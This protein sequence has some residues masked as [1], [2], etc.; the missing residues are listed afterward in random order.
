MNREFWKDRSVFLTGHTGFKG[1]WTALWLSQLGAKVHGYS[2]EPPTTPSF[3]AVTS[4]SSMITSSTIGDIRDVDSLSKA[5]KKASPSVVIHMAAQSLVRESY[6]N[7]VE[8]FSTNVMGTVNVLESVRSLSSVQA[9]LIITS[10]KCYKNTNSMIPFTEDD[11]LGGNDPYSS[12]KA[13]AELITDAYRKSF[14][15]KSNTKIA[16]ARAGNVIGGGDWAKDR[17]IPDVIR[18]LQTSTK[19]RV[20]NLNSIRPWQHVLEPISGYVKVIEKLVQDGDRYAGAWNFGPH[21][22]E[23][24]TV[25]MLL[26]IAKKN[27]RKLKWDSYFNSDRMETTTLAIDSSKALDL[28][29][30]SSKWDIEDSLNKTFD[31]YQVLAN[32]ENIVDFSIQQIQEYGNI[33]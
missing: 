18:S 32:G 25:E 3:F 15:H 19:L 11:P 6:K 13:C 4:L 22:H 1:G 31:W 2:L 8:T 33:S 23:P 30:W 27:N 9:V 7:P 12:S 17:L 28:L 16:T 29:G 21:R 5:M 14:F 20:R 24:V 10:D 26:K